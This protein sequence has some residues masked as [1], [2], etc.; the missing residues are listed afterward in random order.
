[1]AKQSWKQQM[2]QQ[3]ANSQVQQ[4]MQQQREQ[5]FQLAQSLIAQYQ[6]NNDDLA[7]AQSLISQNQ[8]VQTAPVQTV[9]KAA[10]KQESIPSLADFFKPTTASGKDLNKE[11]AN[12]QQRED[13]QKQQQLEQME[14]EGNR[15]TYGNGLNTGINQLDLSAIQN[16]MNKAA[17]QQKEQQNEDLE[18]QILNADRYVVD[19]APQ[20]TDEQK[21]L[22]EQIANFD[23]YQVNK[24]DP[25][26]GKK[27]LAAFGWGVSKIPFLASEFIANGLVDAGESLGQAGAVALDD[28]TGHHDDHQNLEKVNDYWNAKRDQVA[29]NI[30]WVHDSQRQSEE[31]N[32]LAYGAGKFATQAALYA[33]TN[34]LFDKVGS[35]AGAGAGKLASALGASGKT[36][37]VAAKAASI[38]GNQIGQNLQD[39]ALDTIPRYNELKAL[40]MSDDVIKDTLVKEGLINAGGN[41]FFGAV[42]ELPGLVK[43]LGNKPM[44]QLEDVDNVV[45]NATRQAEEATQNIE[46][47]AKQMPETPIEDVT[48]AIEGSPFDVTRAVKDTST[49]EKVDSALKVIAAPI[50]NLEAS[51]AMKNVADAKALQKW[52][53]LKKAYS[54]YANAF[55]ADD[56]SYE[57]LNTAK[58]AMEAKRKAFARA[59]EKIDPE[60]AKTFNNSQYGKTIGQAMYAQLGSEKTPK[61]IEEG[62]R[63]IY[64]AEGKTDAEI[65]DILK[66]LQADDLYDMGR[67]SGTLADDLLNK[68]TFDGSANPITREEF[69]TGQKRLDDIVNG[70]KVMV[71]D[72]GMTNVPKSQSVSAE[73]PIEEASTPPIDGELVERGTSRHI[74]NDG[75]PMKMEDVSDEVVAD[76]EDNKD[77]YV[78]LKNADTKAK[79]EKI[80]AESDNPEVEFRDMLRRHDPAALPLGHQLA[81]DY[82]AAGNH[83]AAAQI[84]REMGEQLTKAGQFSQAAVINMMKNDP[85]TA[86]NYAERQ[87]DNLNQQ[88]LKR[89]GDKWKNFTLTDAEKDL[90]NSIKPGDEAAIKA[91]YDQIG[92]RIGKEYPTTFLEK[93]LEGRKI[94]MLFNLRTMSRNTLANLPTRYLRKFSDRVE[95]LGQNIVHLIDKNYNVT[96]SLTGASKADKQLA[97]DVYNSKRVQEML[98]G[99]PGKYELP[100]LKN[101]L[102]DNKQMFKGTF[103]D[104]FIDKYSGE[105][106]NKV[107]KILGKDTQ[108]DGGLK[109]LN[110]KLYGKENVES[111]LETIRN[112]T[113]KM[114]DMGDSPF[115]KG[116]FVDRL[117]SYIK[118][119]GIKSI[120]DVPDE[121]IQMAWEE[122]MKATYKD[123]SWAVKMTQQ[124]KKGL[125]S[126]PYIGKPLSDALIPF[127]Q[128]PANIAARMVDYSPLRGS[129]G[130][131]DVIQG[132]RKSNPKQLTKGIEEMSK[133]LT[134]TAAAYLGY[135]LYKAGIL[136]GAYAEDADQR[137]FQKQSGFREYALRFGKDKYYT[138]NWMQPAFQNI[139]A[140]VIV[141]DAIKN[142]DDYDSMLLQAMGY[143]DTK[144]GE[145]IG[146]SKQIAEGSLNSWFDQSTMQNIQELFSGGYNKSIA[147]NLAKIAINDFAGSFVPASVNAIA[148]TADTTQRNTTDK[149][150]IINNFIA[151]QK[152]KIPEASKDLPIK[153]DTWGNEMK[154][155]D[156]TLEAAFNRFLNPGEGTTDTSDSVDKEITRLF[157]EATDSDGK[158]L[159]DVGV[160]P[161]IAPTKVGD[162][163][164]NNE[165]NS[166]FQQDMGVRNREIVGEFMDSNAYK[167]MSDQERIES[168]KKIY[169]MSQALTKES[170]FNSEIPEGS[171]YKKYA[172]IYKES[173]AKG[174][175][176][177]LRAKKVLD[178]AG[179]SPNS[180]VGEEITEAVSKGNM[181]E[182]QRLAKGETD[183]KA[184]CKKAGVENANSG[185]RK[186]YEE[187]GLKGLQQYTKDAKTF[188]SH[189]V[190]FND[191]TREIYKDY[192][193]KGLDEYKVLADSGLKNKTPMTIYQSA[194]KDVSK[195]ELPTLEKYAETYKKI[196]TGKNGEIDQKEFIAY[197]LSQGWSQSQIETQA[198]I[199]GDWKT[200]PVLEKGTIKFKK[201]K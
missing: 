86:L 42:S 99:T 162:K 164:L 27:K 166:I 192:D 21:A 2:Y 13:Y 54:D 112:T 116:N 79:A 171:E 125:G 147:G 88:G 33:V 32:P 7:L 95:A 137:A 66:S 194:K 65:D 25:E 36:A 9:K 61:Q 94:A 105:A 143:D 175:T 122:A 126:V 52:E 146:V 90:F 148:K 120:D 141:G 59:M 78:R 80:Y 156:N 70:N 44:P 16:E 139:M 45:R 190:E 72:A 179:I 8:P 24:S 68:Y 124:V 133:G 73:I 128:A 140:G 129:K 51:G 144:I 100:D 12:R 132:A 199:Y 167:E 48:G 11:A 165:E 62:L 34:P 46:N 38:A 189:G 184:A 6:P 20:L 193:E 118:A 150:N 28:L 97:T 64:Q 39:V 96:Q 55:I 23:E 107:A 87:I 160:F 101:A 113:Y 108:I 106:F 47:I 170:K 142:A 155:A 163:T 115:V 58:K 57:S 152:A 104:R 67:S 161:P 17:S 121:A 30:Q 127:V 195:S 180:K 134:G 77:M 196:D 40:G 182:A 187:G 5:D 81:K 3:I 130:V 31:E 159:E 43:K 169:G 76:F 168:I 10:P 74:R 83:E 82:S 174:I 75:T 1:M 98:R 153:Y 84:Y 181:A 176:Q 109:T 178:N 18:R 4:V 91:A 117:G 136:T 119:Q 89:F 37:K 183:Y 145:A 173:G 177:Y 93:L 111:V 69:E 26:K 135:M 56:M 49:A 186:A 185:T 53:D 41:A 110:K 172:D 14:A 92:T 201:K 191:T 197:A 198:K 138:I 151:Q 123:N 200:I 71:E 103:V 22:E 35:V 188:E 85:L 50:D 60:I 131:Y 63:A 149:S 15:P 114:L 29:D 157:E 102:L 19:N 158:K 154:Y